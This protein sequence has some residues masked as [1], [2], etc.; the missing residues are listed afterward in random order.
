M[1]IHGV[2]YW[3]DVWDYANNRP[4]NTKILMTTVVISS[5]VLAFMGKPLD[6]ASITILGVISGG[7]RMLEKY[8]DSGKM[9]AQIKNADPDISARRAIEPGEEPA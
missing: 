6:A 9:V 2:Y 5:I 4:D 1:K 3:L 8:F 7:V